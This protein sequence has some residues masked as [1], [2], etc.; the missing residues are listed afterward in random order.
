MPVSPR[1]L[2]R[3]IAALA[4]GAALLAAVPST[5][6]SQA[7]SGRRPTKAYTIEQFIATEGVGG[8]SFSADEKR[9]LFSSNRSG[10]FNVYDVAVAGGEP[11]ALTTSTTDSTY[12]VSYFPSDDRFLYTRDQGGNELNHLYVRTPDGQDR[13]LTPGDKLKAG[14]AG[15]SRDRKAFHVTTNERDPKTIDVYRYDARTYAR[16]LVFQNPGGFFP[17]AISGDGRYVALVKISTTLDNDLHLFDVRTKKTVH[18]T[19]HEGN[20][21]HDVMEFDPDSKALYYTTDAGGEFERVRRYVL[22]TGKHE[23]VEKDDW[24]VMYTTFSRTGKYRVTAVNRDGQTVVR[25]VETRTGKPLALPRLPAGEITAVEIADSEKRFAFYASGDRSPT[26]LYVWNV[27]DE[28]ARRLTDTLSREIDPEDLVESEVVRFKAADGLEIPNVLFRPHQAT[29]EAKAPALVWVHGGPGGQT[30]RGY[31]AVIQYLA[32]HGYVVLGI[33]NR[34][35]SGYGKTFYGADDK[36]HGKEPLRDCLDAKA[37][38]A[39]LPYVDGNRIGIIGGSYGG[40]MVLAALAFHPQA[41]EAGVDI[42]G[43]ANWVRTLQSIPPWWEAQRKA[44]YEEMGNPET[45]LEML[46][47]ISPL[48]HASRIAK[49]LLVLQGANDPRVLKVESDE[50]VEAVRK[51]GVPVDYVVFPDEGHGFS[52]KKNQIEGYGKVLEFLDRHLKRAPAPGA[53]AAG[54]GTGVGK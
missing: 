13:D 39:S 52:K 41:F 33:N 12:A 45:E 35:S 21:K 29:P 40:Y 46:K 17:G 43:V 1:P 49:P 42:F 51:N 53:G 48:F 6:R 30:R 16:T 10:I 31:S 9:F 26:N 37:Y 19:P 2:L 4:L 28:E 44:L 23:D 34:G 14:F 11:R 20:V 32:N 22:A 3:P 8:G 7:P 24:D 5:A 27:G 36:K 15:W 54:A 25:V 38:L 18:F 50:M 47:E